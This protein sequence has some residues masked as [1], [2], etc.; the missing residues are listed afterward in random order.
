MKHLRIAFNGQRLAGQRFGVGRYIEYLLRHWA[1][2]LD[3]DE[4]VSLF[5][6]QPVG[7]DITG[8]SPRI[9]PTLLASKRSGLVWE[10]MR[11]RGAAAKHDVLFCPAYTA[12]LA[13]RGRMVVANHSVNELQ[14]GAHSWFYKQ[15]YARLHKYSARAADAVIVPGA[16]VRA[17]VTEHYGVP[18]NRIFEVHQGADDVFHPIDDQA[19]LDS[20]RTRFFGHPRPYILFVGKCSARRNIPMLLQAFAKLRRERDIPHGLL[21]FGPEKDGLQVG[22]LCEELGVSKDVV[23][24]DGVVASHGELPPIYAAAD[25][26]VHP[27]ENE[28][29]SMTTV[30]ALACGVP[31]IA[32]DRGGLSDIAR[33]HA[34]MIEPSVE[35]LKAAIDKVLHDDAFRTDLQRKARE[36]GAALGW[37]EAAR[38]TLDIVRSVG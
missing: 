34:F 27:S 7:S 20:V 28:G 23:Q 26:F 17:A 36:R 25:V 5:L 16:T 33:G 32:A 31:V 12:P 19:L 14:D 21:L 11:L 30:E 24:T 18:N 15:S 1:S 10:N 9:K 22:A 29:W 37:R 3:A 2:F 8:L 13:F 38:R 6:R 35:T 4:E